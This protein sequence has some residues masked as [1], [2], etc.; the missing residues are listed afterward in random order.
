MKVLAIDV[1]GNH[2]KTL[3]SGKRKPRRFRSG[4]RLTAARMAD[5]V[6]DLTGDW[7]YDAVSIGYPGPVLFGRPVVD[8]LNL[9]PGWVGFDYAAAFRHPVKIV[10][11]AAMQAMGSY[12]GGTMLFL[13]LGTGLGVALIRDG[14]VEPLELGQGRYRK[15]TYADY[16]GRAGLMRLGRRTWQKRVFDVV[17]RLADALKPEDIVIGGGN[18]KLLTELPRGCRA[19]DNRNA[20]TGGFLL[21]NHE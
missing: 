16:V 21:W 4:P 15:S 1:G 14:L 7:D 5:G 18:V 6:R 9:G 20:F 10:N 13:G 8:P 3:L 19:G 12:Q 2:V 11:D 17:A